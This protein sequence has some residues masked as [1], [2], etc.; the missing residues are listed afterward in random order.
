MTSARRGLVVLWLGLVACA[1]Y[2]RLTRPP[3]PPPPDAQWLDGG[4]GR[5]FVH[6]EGPT[7]PGAVLWLVQG[8]ECRGEPPYPA[9]RAALADARVATAYVH[10]RGSGYSDGLRGDVEQFD[11]LME[12]LRR[13]ADWLGARFPNAP[14]FVLGH[15]AGAAFAL[16][17]IA[18][19]FEPKGLVLVNAAFRLQT[20]PGLAPTFGDVLGFMGNAVF[21]PAA[22]TVDMN[23][24]PQ[25]VQHEADR[26]E[27]LALQA[28]PL[29]VRYF[30]MRFMTGQKA[31][32]DRSAVNV[33][34]LRAPLLVIEGERDALVDPKGNDELLAKAGS[35]ERLR[36]LARDAGHGSSAVEGST[37]V[38]VDWLLR[39]GAAAPIF[40]TPKDTKSSPSDGGAAE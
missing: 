1:S 27:G 16:E 22:L 39:H 32:M 25:A 35:A 20:S 30:S 11:L 2:P 34:R 15:S 10:V 6:T 29:V 38:L 24:R 13:F 36:H 19:G 5:L 21:R 9:L 23:S 3:L 8:A 40:S 31:V 33:A 7:E 26:E 14:V 17:L 37:D 28:D 4:A 18:R 12:D